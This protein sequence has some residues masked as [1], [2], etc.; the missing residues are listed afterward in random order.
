MSNRQFSII[1][2]Q[3]IINDKQREISNMV[4]LMVNGVNDLNKQLENQRIEL[5]KLKNPPM[6]KEALGDVSMKES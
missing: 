3:N 5:E 6:P 1:E 2:L 4:N